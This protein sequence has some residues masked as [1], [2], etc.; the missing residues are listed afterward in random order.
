MK[1]Q[2]I[3][4]HGGETFE[5]YEDYLNYLKNK[6]I[7]FPLVRKTDWKNSLEQ[8][9]GDGFEVIFPEMP[10]KYNAKYLEWKIWFEKLVPFFEKEVVL[11]GHSLGGIFLAKYLSENV[12]KNKVRGLFLVSAPYDCEN[13]T[14]DYE[15]L[16]DFII[17]ENFD[18]L[19]GQVK[20]ENIFI[21]H[22]KDDNIVSFKD[23]EKY[24]K[25]LSGANLRIFEDRKHFW[26]Q[27]RFK[28]LE[29]DIKSLY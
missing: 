21:Y 15:S 25:F 22:S 24:A 5:T 11:V 12:L 9:L 17:P 27:D 26:G 13:L 4:I 23:F 1:R 29:E 2:I 28:E 14:G 10:S 6:E 3:L 8:N 7:D 16:G 18:I 20:K 19:K